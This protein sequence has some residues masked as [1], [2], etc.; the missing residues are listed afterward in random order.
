MPLTR[1]DAFIVG[2]TDGTVRPQETT[3]RA[4]AATILFR[5]SSDEERTRLWRQDNPFTDVELDN[6]FNNA[7]STM[8]NAGVITG[9][10]DGRFQPG[11]SI[12]RAELVAAIIRFKGL[13]Q[14]TGTPMFNDIADHWAMGYINTAAHQGWATGYDGAGGSF[15]PDQAI[16]RA[17]TAALI[18]RMLNRL[19]EDKSDLL[20][21][22]I[23]WPDNNNP[24]AWYYLYIQE[25]TNSHYYVRKADGI[26][27]TWVEMLEPRQWTLLE[28]PHSR[29]EDILRGR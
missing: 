26:H 1:H 10:P 12:T 3:T 23:R 8:A 13:E 21:N 22:M 17:E 24:S 11:R 16:T 7:I 9:M 4:H 25:A 14:S 28:R 18:N 6:W 15:L 27:E 2:F 20:D 19:P 29:P 5:L